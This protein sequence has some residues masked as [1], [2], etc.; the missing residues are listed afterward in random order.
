MNSDRKKP[1]VA[2][3]ATVVA[4]VV[5]VAYPVSFGPA[6]WIVSRRPGA[7]NHRWL[8]DIYWPIGWWANRSTLAEKA[9][10]G[11]ARLGMLEHSDVLVPKGDK[12]GLRFPKDPE[13]AF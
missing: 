5:L 4:V 1:G 6:C 10:S 11:F 7:V 3:W 2:L 8:P 13:Q 12:W 9:T